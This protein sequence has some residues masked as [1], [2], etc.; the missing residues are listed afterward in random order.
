ML[1]GGVFRG[2]DQSLRVFDSENGMLLLEPIEEME[3]DR[4]ARQDCNLIARCGLGAAL[5]VFKF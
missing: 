2:E 1:L 4:L 5:I 3:C